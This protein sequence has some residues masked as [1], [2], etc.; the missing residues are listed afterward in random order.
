MADAPTP[1]LLFEAG[2]QDCGLRQAELPRPIPP[3]GDDVDWL[4][5]DYDSFRLFMLEE[6]AGRFPERRRWT[7]ADL[8]VI[9][10]E[11]LSVIL[12]RLSDQLDRAHAEAF[13]D[14]AR[15]PDSLR[16]L[17]ALIGY[18]AVR[19]HYQPA[20]SDP[21]LI[22]HLL[23]FR[24]H[25]I[26]SI[27]F[28]LDLLVPDNL[29]R[30]L[31]WLGHPADSLGPVPDLR[32]RATER[33]FLLLLGFEVH[34]LREALD[35]DIGAHRQFAT[36]ALERRWRDQAH[37]MDTARLAGPRAV[38]RNRRMV[39]L[40][41]YRERL[42][43]HPLVLRAASGLRWTGSWQTLTLSC[44]LAANLQLEQ[45]PAD[46]LGGDDLAALQ[47]AV[48]RF[49]W[50]E[51][52]APVAWTE[53][54]NSRAILRQLLD[55]RRMTGQE[56]WLQD[57]TPVGI[58]LGLSLRVGANYFQSEIRQAVA[59]RLGTG[60]EGF[61]TPGRLAFGED[62]HASDLVEWLMALDGVEAVCLNRFK[63]V[64]ARYADQSGS[65]LIRLDDDQ[66]ARCDNDLSRPALGYWTL[67]LHGGQ[68]G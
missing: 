5:R 9:L 11:A 36:A 20:W 18:D 55:R 7:P 4:I 38:H 2:C 30:L 66:I 51:N 41:D 32:D 45:T 26:A 34:N 28:A 56:V 42:E 40:Q 52:L 12:D 58:R 37:L 31:A 17:L 43:D 53:A 47:D 46:R 59:Q 61:F 16:R 62:L 44:V 54:P 57:A 35:L 8:E 13:L 48:D 27:E 23:Q 10:V 6:L 39:S 60:P 25:D 50:R 14:S 67:K 19:E 21:L 1:E 49:H 15:R 3:I 33:A 22:R 24:G 68:R 64:G 29:R 63:R 65:G